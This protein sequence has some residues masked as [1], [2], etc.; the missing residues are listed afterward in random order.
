MSDPLLILAGLVLLLAGGEALIRGAVALA[1]R[2]G[3]SPTV[4]GLTVVGFGTSMPELVTSLNAALIGAPAI[5]IGNVVGSNIANILLILGAAA[6]LA[7][8]ALPQSAWRDLGVM[9]AASAALAVILLS[10]VV[11][12]TDGALLFVGL[13]AYLV[14]A[15]RT[16]GTEEPSIPA[17]SA[18]V[19]AA[20][21]VAGIVGLSI[22]AS[23]MVNGAVS[24]ATDL[25]LSQAVIGVTIVAVG[26][27][28]PEL[29]ASVTAARRGEGAM[30]IGNVVGSNIFNVLGIL[31]V[32]ALVTPVPVD[33]AFL[34]LDVWVM[35]GAALALLILPLSGWRI[36]R[37]VGAALLVGYAAYL[38]ALI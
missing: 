35:A 20:L 30:A 37:G 31:G 1:G 6:V 16:G 25:G 15:L 5:A 9:L 13:L 33:P 22:G 3:L 10:E 26:T 12:R 27:S 34:A 28:L 32:T 7:P 19:A 17:L 38:W 24:L 4:I 8:L 2:S 23:L 14:L 18:P 11:T 36:G 21:A 29:A